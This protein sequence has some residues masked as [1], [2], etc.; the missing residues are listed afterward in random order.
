MNYGGGDMAVFKRFSDWWL[1][2]ELYDKE[3]K[4]I[5]QEDRD[6]YC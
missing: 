3:R 2:I 6:R 5:R 1:Q 4:A